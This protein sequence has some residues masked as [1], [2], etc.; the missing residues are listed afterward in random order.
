M[1]SQGGELGMEL[2]GQA[3]PSEVL[4]MV[5]RVEGQM[6]ERPSTR[7]SQRV[8]KGTIGTEEARVEGWERR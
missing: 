6:G 3:S 8:G 2:H 4:A 5:V 1:R 7:R